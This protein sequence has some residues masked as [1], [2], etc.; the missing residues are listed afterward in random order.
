MR[1]LRGRSATYLV[2]WVVALAVVLCLVHVYMRLQVITLGYEISRARKL[3]DTYAEQNQKLQLELAV[4]KYPA[5]IERRAQED[6]HMVQPDP[7]AIR[8]LGGSRPP[9]A[10]DAR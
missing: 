6:L 1:I 5:V 9:A 3:R 7:G 2:S 10:G 8:V 4:R